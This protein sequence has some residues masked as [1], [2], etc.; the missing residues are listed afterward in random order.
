MTDRLPAVR[1]TAAFKLTVC[2]TCARDE[3]LAEVHTILA[4]GDRAEKLASADA[5]WRTPRKSLRPT[6]RRRTR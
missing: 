1:F 4:A 2:T 5:M 3:A 6:P